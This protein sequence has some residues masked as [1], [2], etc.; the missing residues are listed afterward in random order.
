[1]WTLLLYL[2]IISGF[3]MPYFFIKAIR[4]KDDNFKYTLL[5]CASFGIIILTLVF[6]LT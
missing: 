5:T 2:S 1:M 4:T 6:P 3:V